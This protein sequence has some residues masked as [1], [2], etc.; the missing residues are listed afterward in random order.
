MTKTFQSASVDNEELDPVPNP[1][2]TDNRDN[3]VVKSALKLISQ[4][5]TYKTEKDAKNEKLIDL[6]EKGFDLNE[7]DTLEK[8]TAKKLQQVYWKTASRM[9]P[10]DVVV[11]G[12]QRPEWV[13]KIVTDGVNTVLDLSGF[14]QA[15]RD[16][17][18]AFQ[19][20][21]VGGD[22][23]VLFGTR[24][25]GKGFPFK[26]LPIPSN[27]LYFDKNATTM[28]N[29]SKPA[30]KV[31]LIISYSWA[32][33]IQEYPDMEET[34][35]LGKIPRDNPR[36]DVDQKELQQ[37]S[38]EDVVEVCHYYDLS[39]L[40]YVSFAGSACTVIEE[41]G[42]EG[43]EEYSWII[44]DKFSKVQK[45]YI[46]ILQLMCVESFKGFYNHGILEMIYDIALEYKKLLNMGLNHS[47]DNTYP[48]TALNIPAGQADSVFKQL[49][50]AGQARAKGK[51]P[52]VV[53][54]Y[55]GTGSNQ[56]ALQSLTSGNQMGETQI[57]L[58]LMDRECKRLGVHL[59]EMEAANATATQILSDEEN[60]N[61]FVKQM[62]EKN[63][64]EFKF[65]YEIVLDQIPKV[66]SKNDETPLQCTTTV[67]IPVAD[68]KDETARQTFE[69]A[70][71]QTVPVKVGGNDKHPNGITLGYLSNELKE[72]NYFVKVNARSGANTSKMRKAQMLNML[73]MTAPGSAAR[74]TLLTQIS[75]MNDTDIKGEDY[76]MPQQ[77]P[78][79]AL[80]QTKG[81]N[82]PAETERTAIN[83]RASEPSAIF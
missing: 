78:Q 53:V 58:E 36:K 73:N 2:P 34:A 14:V 49:E 17:G 38:V 27:N 42:T 9:K 7:G 79:R 56:I 82:A 64:S 44:K 3:K 60:A 69:K 28:R 51:K 48:Y 8:L 12:S 74:T 20:L 15:L 30:K 72:F 16:K 5:F 4:N 37:N 23:F 61:A 33:F 52:F 31:A 77:A 46:P 65:L 29:G 71:K 35:G 63:A 41:K 66:I 40:A 39:N 67:Q 83:V 50:M 10:L 75:Q 45:P 81:Q 70:G 24:E 25:K 1:N 6:V 22:G 68:I 26:F 54:E 62:M 13:E 55:D 21:L 19:N 76:S 57:L 80:P 32:E 43:K 47:E 59:D 11:H 18:G